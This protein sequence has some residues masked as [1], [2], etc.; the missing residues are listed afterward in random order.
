MVEWLQQIESSEWTKRGRKITNQIVAEGAAL[1]TGRRVAEAGHLR[2][3]YQ[4]SAS[5][6]APDGQDGGKVFVFPDSKQL[7]YFRVQQ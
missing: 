7:L 4:V 3:S 1:H 5:N 2:D 6:S